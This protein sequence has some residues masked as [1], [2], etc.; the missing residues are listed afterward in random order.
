MEC[1]SNV[2]SSVF[3]L[4]Q[5][6]HLLNIYSIKIYFLGQDNFVSVPNHLLFIYFY[7]G[8][9]LVIF[10]S[11]FLLTLSSFFWHS[12]TFFDC[13]RYIYDSVS[14]LNCSQNKLLSASC[15]RNFDWLHLS[16]VSS[17]FQNFSITFSFRYFLSLFILFL[18]S[19]PPSLSSQPTNPWNIT[20][21]ET[22]LSLG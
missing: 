19:W 15:L 9:V 10:F 8:L 3:D 14:C 17:W 16:L 1:V 21:L 12:K 2:W 4:A 6:F 18:L 7:A 13:L 22:A 5:S 20:Q 11:Y